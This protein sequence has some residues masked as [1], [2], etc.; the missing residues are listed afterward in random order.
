[1]ELYANKNRPYLEMFGL[2]YDK[3]LAV[4]Y[5]F[6]VSTAVTVGITGTTKPGM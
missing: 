3:L 4:P 6:S 5:L 2:S 1:M